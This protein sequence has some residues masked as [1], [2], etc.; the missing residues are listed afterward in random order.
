MLC[1]VIDT[2]VSMRK[3]HR[4][5]LESGPLH[6]YDVVRFLFLIHRGWGYDGMSIRGVC[7]AS[8]IGM[9][10]LPCY[11]RRLHNYSIQYFESRMLKQTTTFL[12]LRQVYIILAL[13][14]WNA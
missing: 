10:A 6:L 3:D 11:F 7:V 14:T 4:R 9:L 12:S 5:D 1:P 13:P 2:L 8:V